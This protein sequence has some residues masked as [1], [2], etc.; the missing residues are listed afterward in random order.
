MDHSHEIHGKF[1]LNLDLNPAKTHTTHDS[2]SQ[3][4]ICPLASV[5]P[6]SCLHHHS[7]PKFRIS[8]PRLVRNARVAI[9]LVPGAPLRIRAVGV[10]LSSSP[11]SYP[12]SVTLFER[13][14]KELTS[15]THRQV[16][17][18]AVLVSSGEERSQT[19]SSKK[20]KSKND[21]RNVVFRAWNF[22]SSKLSG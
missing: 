8:V 14:D 15:G 3:M 4:P 20:R 1:R 21:L 5:S 19:G 16:L 11:P 17:S 10:R 6:C 2:T 9:P 12:L 7:A 18:F 13:K 22:P